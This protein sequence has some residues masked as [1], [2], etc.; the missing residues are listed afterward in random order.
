MKNFNNEYNKILNLGSLHEEI[1][2]E[3][4]K[5]KGKTLSIIMMV[6][7]LILIVLG[8]FYPQISELIE[9]QKKANDKTSI[10]NKND[11]I[12]TCTVTKTDTT[13]G[14]TTTTKNTYTFK[15]DLLKELKVTKIYKVTENNYDAGVSNISLYNTKYQEL[16]NTLASI[17][18]IKLVY[19]LEDDELVT[20][21]DFSLEKID[22]TKIPQNNLITLSNKLDQ[23]KKE[24][25]E[26]E[27]K[28]GHICK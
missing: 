11:N 21:T 17:E 13:I 12:L 3:Q 20:T 18:G 27:G 19:N 16:S 23:T 28:A 25:K 22:Q 1:I 4:E 2:K 14:I 24:I 15:K 8:I 6:I 9:A 7:G 10:N 26:I 5:Q